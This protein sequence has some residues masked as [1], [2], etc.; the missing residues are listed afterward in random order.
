MSGIEKFHN[1]AAILTRSFRVDDEAIEELR[2]ILEH[3]NQRSI[4]HDQAEEVGR[5]L[6]TVIETLANGRT[7]TANQ[8]E[9]HET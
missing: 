3:Q 9:K 2:V 4:T 6:I 7:I 8:E 1:I 5:K